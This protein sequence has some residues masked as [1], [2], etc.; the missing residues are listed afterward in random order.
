MAQKPSDYVSGR[1]K[2]GP[3]PCPT[4]WWVEGRDINTTKTLVKYIGVFLGAPADVAK[5]G[6]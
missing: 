4:G 6:K 1:S 2:G 3:T 5:N